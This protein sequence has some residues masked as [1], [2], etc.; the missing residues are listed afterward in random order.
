MST[1]RKSHTISIEESLWKE[2]EERADKKHMSTSRLIED[3]V[4]KYLRVD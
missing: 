3:L 2:V 4:R 1:L